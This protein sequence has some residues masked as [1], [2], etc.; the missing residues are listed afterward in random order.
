MFSEAICLDIFF[1]IFI[2]SVGGSEERFVLS[3]EV[4]ARTKKKDNAPNAIVAGIID[5]DIL[6][7]DQRC[8]H[9]LSCVD[10]YQWDANPN[11]LRE[12]P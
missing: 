4:L 9:A 10:Q 2:C 5:N 7:I 8:S 1:S 12:K 3:K 11:L 6:H